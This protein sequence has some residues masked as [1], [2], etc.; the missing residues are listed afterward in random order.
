MFDGNPVCPV[1]SHCLPLNIIYHLS[2]IID[3]LSRVTCTIQHKPKTSTAERV[4]TSQ[5]GP[6]AEEI[7]G[8]DG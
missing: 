8:T 3:H 7:S 6:Q 5:Q 4:A 1:A 2:S